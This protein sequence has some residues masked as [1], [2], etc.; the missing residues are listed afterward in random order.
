MQ[1]RLLGKG[2]NLKLQKAMDIS[3]LLELAIRHLA[4]IQNELKSAAASFSKIDSKI[5]IKSQNSKVF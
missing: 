4:I 3:L 2:A 5:P 1:Q